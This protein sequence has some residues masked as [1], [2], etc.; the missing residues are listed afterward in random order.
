MEA[1]PSQDQFQID[2]YNDHLQLHFS[3]VQTT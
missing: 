3:N 1:D 2:S